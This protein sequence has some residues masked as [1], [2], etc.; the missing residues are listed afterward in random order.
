MDTLTKAIA[1]DKQ[2][3]VLLYQQYRQEIFRFILGRTGDREA[4]LDLTSD[5][6][7]AAFAGISGFK[8]ESSFRTWLYA[9][10]KH[11]LND[12][13]AN[14][15]EEQQMFASPEDSGDGLD[16]AM[17]I[18]IQAAAA[19]NSPM[20]SLESNM[21]LES[22]LCKLTPSAQEILLLH[23][24]NGLN[25]E[26][27]GQTLNISTGNARVLHYRAMVKARQLAV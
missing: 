4:A 7:L 17:E 26:E 20:L 13:Y 22:I 2:A 15:E 3:F 9:I 21:D 10:C 1:G 6:F 25:F 8:A 12:F 19:G 23:N 5:V 27:C 16:N 14:N 11:K 24:V 18:G